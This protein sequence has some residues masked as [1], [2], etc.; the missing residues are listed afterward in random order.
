[1]G[2]GDRPCRHGSA[3]EDADHGGSKGRRQQGTPMIT[4]LAALT[5]NDREKLSMTVKTAGISLP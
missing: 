5:K 2:I 4:E 1:M 3:P